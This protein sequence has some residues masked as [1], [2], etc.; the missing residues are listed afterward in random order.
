MRT[1]DR[2]LDA[3]KARNETTR[4]SYFAEI[5]FGYDT[6]TNAAT[7]QATVLISALAPP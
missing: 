7:N 6:N 1:L 5:E 3:I 4:V 2:Y